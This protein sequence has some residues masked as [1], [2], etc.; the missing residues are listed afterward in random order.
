MRHVMEA[1]TGAHGFDFALRIGVTR[2]GGGE[3]GHGEH[4][5]TW[6]RDA[7]VV[8]G[9]F[10]DRHPC[11][12]FHSG[13]NFLEQANICWDIEMVDEVGDQHR[14]IAGP[15]ICGEGAAF[16]RMPAVRDPEFDGVLMG[17]R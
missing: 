6:G 16:D 2:R 3:H 17:D 5:R 14:I 12:R 9:H 1:G 4:A 10:H 7:I 13:A 11:P 15:I 8:D